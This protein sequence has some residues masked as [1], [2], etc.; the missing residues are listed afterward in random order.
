MDDVLN[1]SKYVIKFFNDR[2]KNI[3]NLKL[4]KILY[5]IQ[6]YF[7]KHFDKGAFTDEIYAW[8]YGP[9]VPYVYYEYSIN[10]MLPLNCDEQ[11]VTLNCNEDEIKVIRSV[12]EKCENITS[13]ELVEKTHSEYPW[14]TAEK[15]KIIPK[16]YISYYF[17]NN[18]PLEM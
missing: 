12:M 7:Y 13:Y 10:R 3:T 14:Q 17:K 16:S 1:I 8:T 5:Y 18:N 2:N 11:F 15:G 9:V 6:G 4:Q